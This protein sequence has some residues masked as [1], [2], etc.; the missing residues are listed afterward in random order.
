MKKSLA[1]T[2]LISGLVT[3]GLSFASVAPMVQQLS[4]FTGAFAG[5]NFGIRTVD[6][7][8][9]T[10]NTDFIPSSY[11]GTDSITQPVEGLN[12]G[13]GYQ[14]MNHLYM[15]A[16]GFVQIA[17]GDS[18]YS[19]IHGTSR[20]QFRNV[21]GLN[22]QLGYAVTDR[23]LPYVT[24]GYEWLN[25]QDHSEYI[26]LLANEFNY[27]IDQYKG[28]LD[29]GVGMKFK[30]TNHVLINTEFT[31]AYISQ[32]GKSITDENGGY[33]STKIQPNVYTGL[34]GFSYLF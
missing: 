14:F 31:A 20:E 11:K 5:I 10:I 21:Y 4:S 13:Y 34:I 22:A 28:G 27:T 12:A 32:A 15:G 23:F 3:T 7:N 18:R 26:G 24:A 1:L 17:Q 8:Y 25:I 2:T 16:Q 29:A 6:S 19:D 33:V 30:M 9:T